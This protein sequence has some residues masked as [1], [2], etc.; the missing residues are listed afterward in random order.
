MKPHY[1]MRIERILRWPRER[2]R[3]VS[4][5]ELLVWVEES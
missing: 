1:T 4:Q 2:L 3:V 5:K